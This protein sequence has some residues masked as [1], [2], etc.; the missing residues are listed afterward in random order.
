MRRYRC[1]IGFC[2]L[3]ILKLSLSLSLSLQTQ[4]FLV[5]GSQ[6]LTELRD[7]IR[8]LTDMVMQKAD[9]YDP[10]GYF[11]I[12]VSYGLSCLL[13]PKWL[14]IVVLN[15]TFHCCRI[16]SAMTQGTLLLLT[17]VSQFFIGLRTARKRH[18]QNGT[19]FYP[20]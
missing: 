1:T 12:E 19:P 18:L 17:I 3:W 20:A 14:L 15:Q 5:L 7:N 16:F 10:S 13:C 9:A 4:E 11:L 8:C 2:F 6:T